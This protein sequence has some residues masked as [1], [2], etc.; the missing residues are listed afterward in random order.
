MGEFQELKK[1]INQ[2]RSIRHFTSLR[3]LG[4]KGEHSPQISIWLRQRYH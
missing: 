2:I 3:G 4:K 1:K